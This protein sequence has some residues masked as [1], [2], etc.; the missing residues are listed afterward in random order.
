MHID[1]RTMAFCA[2]ARADF[3]RRRVFAELAAFK[4]DYLALAGEIKA[5][6]LQLKARNIP[7]QWVMEQLWRLKGDTPGWLAQA[8]QLTAQGVRITERYEGTHYSI[9][10]KCNRL[11]R[12]FYAASLLS[13]AG[14]SCAPFL[15]IGSGARAMGALALSFFLYLMAGKA[16]NA[17]EKWQN[18]N[19]GLAIAKHATRHSPQGLVEHL[20]RNARADAGRE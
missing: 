9:Q 19:E 16:G 5:E 3:P 7:D 11:G 13:A 15:A 4:S 20:Q 14:I 8:S 12:N 1:R 10:C 2:P 18:A 6:F 17:L